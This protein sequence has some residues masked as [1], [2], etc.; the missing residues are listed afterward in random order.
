MVINLITGL[1]A[2]AT[3]SQVTNR[4]RKRRLT[5]SMAVSKPAS[6]AKQV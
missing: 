2:D 1:V 5:G 3:P 6:I 4:Q